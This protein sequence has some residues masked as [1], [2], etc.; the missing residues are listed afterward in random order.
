MSFLLLILPLELSLSCVLY[1][2]WYKGK[3]SYM[4]T[5]SAVR[6]SQGAQRSL[7]RL[8]TT[9]CLAQSITNIVLRILDQSIARITAKSESDH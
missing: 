3:L 5:T 2:L 8:D 4:I 6:V 1:A 7:I 9:Y